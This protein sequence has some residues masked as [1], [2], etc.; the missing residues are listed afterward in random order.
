MG[1]GSEIRKKLIPGDAGIIK[2][3]VPGSRILDLLSRI[4]DPI[5]A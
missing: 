4:S 3:P 2:D 5:Y 1:L